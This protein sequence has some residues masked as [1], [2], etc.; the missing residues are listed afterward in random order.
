MDPH[1]RSHARPSPR[2]A[3][4]PSVGPGGA[5]DFVSK[6]FEMGALMTEVRT[7]MEAE[8]KEVDGVDTGASG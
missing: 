5:A 8:E 4:V 7:L 3:A 2:R 6:P 1:Q